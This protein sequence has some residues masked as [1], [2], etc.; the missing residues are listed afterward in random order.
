MRR[1]RSGP[2]CG[3]HSEVRPRHD[4]FPNLN[5]CSQ[6][7]GEQAI[8]QVS[9]ESAAHPG[10]DVVTTYTIRPDEQWFTAKTRFENTTGADLSAWI[11]DVIDH[12]GAGQHSCV[13]GHGASTTPYANPR[14]CE[15]TGPW[16]GMSGTDPQTFGLIYGP[17]TPAWTAYGNGNWITSQIQV[18]QKGTRALH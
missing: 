2:S 14:A 16:I 15:P 7:S 8:V 5:L 1:R 13:A 12:D 3:D 10:L 18:V 17:G 6:D 4:G 11:G 9:G